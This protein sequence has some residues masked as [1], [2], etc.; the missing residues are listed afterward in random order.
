MRPTALPVVLF[1]AAA[2]S[3]AQPDH[4][5]PEFVRAVPLPGV[6]GRIDH[7]AFDPAGGKVFVAALGNGSLESVDLAAGRAD[8]AAPGLAEPQ[9]IVFLPEQRRVMVSCGGDGSV[10]GF[11]GATLAAGAVADLGDDADNVR[12]VEGGRTLAIGHGSGAVT[13]VDAASLA[14]QHSLD[15]GGHPESFQFDAATG[16]VFVNVPG[17]AAG[18]CVVVGDLTKGKVVARWPLGDYGANFPMALDAAQRRLY[19]GCRRPAALLVLDLDSGAR[20]AT[21]PCVGDADDVFVD[22]ATGRVLVIGGG[23]AIDVFA[24]A[25]ARTWAKIG[26]VPTAPGARTGLLVPERRTLFVAV[27]A[28]GDAAAELREY[29]LR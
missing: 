26:A 1:L 12:V 3:S 27:P 20:L 7:L 23:G 19:V 8:A 9:G 6:T 21:L 24:A 28:R 22:A 25:D 17:A 14:V 29:R 2:C 13:A 11:D 4:G 5:L 18:P 16:R 15:V 10:R